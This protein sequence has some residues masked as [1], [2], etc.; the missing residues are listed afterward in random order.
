[1]ASGSAYDRPAHR[2]LVKRQPRP[3]AP[4]SCASGDFLREWRATA[5]HSRHKSPLAGYAGGTG[6]LR[7]RNAGTDLVHHEAK[8]GVGVATLGRLEDDHV[9]AGGA[10]LGDG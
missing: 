7:S 4:L 2:L 10:A 8:E 1:M 9:G 3:A 5:R 6:Y